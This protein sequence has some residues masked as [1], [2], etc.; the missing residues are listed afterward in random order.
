MLCPSPFN[1]LLPHLRVLAEERSDSWSSSPVKVRQV[2]QAW[3]AVLG[4]FGGLLG[5]KCCSGA[6]SM[7][8]PLGNTTASRMK[9]SASTDPGSSW[10]PPKRD[11]LT[12]K[13]EQRGG[14]RCFGVC[15][16]WLPWSRS[17]RSPS[18]SG[19]F[20]QPSSPRDQPGMELGSCWNR[21]CFCVCPDGKRCRLGTRGGTCRKSSRCL[22]SVPGSAP[23]APGEDTCGLSL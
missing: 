14:R 3:R 11:L 10:H 23:R 7:Q 12:D 21:V 9:I 18:W 15:H 5:A 6:R 1:L 22:A 4:Q 2:V 13:K 20:K 17:M 19:G 16:G 8:R